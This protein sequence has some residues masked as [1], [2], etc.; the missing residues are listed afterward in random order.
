MIKDLKELKQLLVLCRKQ[1][2]TEIKFG[3]VEFKLG[4]LP[5]EA[6]EQ[7]V[8]HDATSPYDNFPEG[9]LSMEQLA[10]YSSGGNPEDDPDNKDTSQ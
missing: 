5:Y 3:E 7:T 4:E 8:E 9:E 2:V 1:G 6:P 10:F